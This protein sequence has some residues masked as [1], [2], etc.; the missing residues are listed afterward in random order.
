MNVL[1]WAIKTVPVHTVLC[2]IS[3]FEASFSSVAANVSLISLKEILL[4]YDGGHIGYPSIECFFEF[5]NDWISRYAT[6]HNV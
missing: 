1:L 6:W 5:F 4:I 3:H 2:T